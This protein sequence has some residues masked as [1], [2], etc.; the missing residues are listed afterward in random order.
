MGVIYMATSKT[1]GKSYIGKT[2]KNLNARIGEHVAVSQRMPRSHFHKALVKYGQQDFEWAV[3]CQAPSHALNRLERFY[4]RAFGTYEHGYNSTLGGDGKSGWCHSG[5]TRRKISL[6]LRGK[7][8]GKSRVFSVQHKLALSR[9]HKGHSQPDSQKLAVS[10]PILC[11]ETGYIFPSIR[12][13]AEML[14]ISKGNISSVLAGRRQRA[15]GFT[16]V[17]VG[18]EL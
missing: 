11:V 4:I 15:G 5:E 9:S 12:R 18:R 10:K 8:S 6:A 17:F 2:V 1:T 3:V 14:G 7:N 13:A 16:F